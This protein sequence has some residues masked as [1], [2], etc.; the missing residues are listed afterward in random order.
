MRVWADHL[1]V[2]DASQVVARMPRLR[3]QGKH[4]IEYRHVI[5]S[6]VRKPGAFARYRWR[7]DLFPGVLFR[8]AYDEL[9]EDCPGTADPRS[10]SY[11]V[12]VSVTGR[13][14]MLT[15]RWS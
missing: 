1:E 6:L 9:R 15:R 3:G 12:A 2:R 14:A 10:S 7:A 5:H 13:P 8:V 11:S 4:R